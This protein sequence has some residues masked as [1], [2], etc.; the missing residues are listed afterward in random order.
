MGV[1]GKVVMYCACVCMCVH[2]RPGE[3]IIFRVQRDSDMP[4]HV[5]LI[6]DCVTLCEKLQ[7]A[8]SNVQI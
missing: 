6:A 8:N 7:T 3:V 1:A 4:T 5:P 2:T